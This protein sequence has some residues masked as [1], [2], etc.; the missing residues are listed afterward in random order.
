MSTK[1]YNAYRVVADPPGG[2]WAFLR[3]LQDKAREEAKKGIRK[4]QDD[5]AEAVLPEH[6]D[7]QRYIKWG[8]S[9]SRARQ[10]VAWDLLAKGYRAQASSTRSNP[11]NF[12]VS[13]T[14]REH[15]GRFY[16]Q[17]FCGDLLHGVLDFL[18]TMPE[19]EEYY[20]FNNADN[21]ADVSDEAWEERAVTWEAILDRGWHHFLVMD[22]VTV[23]GFYLFNNLLEP[24]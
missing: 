16:L 15:E 8:W 11:F 12:D 13:I 24:N 17:A 18:T 6:E 19:L 7:Y 1:I 20:Y 4:I 23:G 3:T 14:V 10:M 5:F 22:I 2:I 21:P 9:E